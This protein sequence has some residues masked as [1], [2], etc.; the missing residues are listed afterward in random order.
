M[1]VAVDPNKSEDCGSLESK[2]TLVVVLR[3]YCWPKLLDDWVANG[4]V[5]F[6]FLAVCSDKVTRRLKKIEFQTSAADSLLPKRNS[7]FLIER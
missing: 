1:A 2:T 5:D 6:D 7:F 3:F 4:E